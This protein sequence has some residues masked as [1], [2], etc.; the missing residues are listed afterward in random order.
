MR[1]PLT[2][3][4]DGGRIVVLSGIHR[5]RR[6]IHQPWKVIRMEGLACMA[7]DHS[8]FCHPVIAI[9]SII[10]SQ[11]AGYIPKLT[12]LA[13]AEVAF[14]A[15]ISC[16]CPKSCMGNFNCFM[17]DLECAPLCKCGGTCYK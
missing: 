1:L 7:R 8:Q 4:S 14:L 10:Q 3:F 6:N 13:I 15:L 12:I 11:T 5:L 16:K 9:N 17:A 2:M